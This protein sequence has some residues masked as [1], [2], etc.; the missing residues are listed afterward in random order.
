MM[1]LL[2]VLFKMLYSLGGQLPFL[3]EELVMSSRSVLV[4]FPFPQERSVRKSV[5]PQCVGTA[6]LA[7]VFM[8][9]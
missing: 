9:D 5:W 3:K 8:F 6:R 1:L 2:T 4:L 7:Q